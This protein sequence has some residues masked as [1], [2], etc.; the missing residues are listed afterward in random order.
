MQRREFTAGNFSSLK[1]AGE[2][3]AVIRVDAF[4]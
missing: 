3:N 4:G 2:P 1:C